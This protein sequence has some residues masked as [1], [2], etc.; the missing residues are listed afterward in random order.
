MADLVD[1]SIIATHVIGDQI[2]GLNGLRLNLEQK[3][4]G[5]VAA[6]NQS[7]CNLPP[8]PDFLNCKD[9]CPTFQISAIA[10]I[11]RNGKVF[12][13]ISLYRKRSEKFDEESFR[14]LEIIASQTGI[15]LSK[16]ASDGDAPLTDSVTALPNGFQLYLM[17]DQIAM[18]AHR[19]E[20]PLAVFSIHL[21]DLTTIRNKWG[22]ITRDECLRAV[23]K[24]LSEGLRD[25]DLLVRYG[26]DDFVT[27]NPRMDREQAEALKSRLQNELD[28][29]RFAV[30]ADEHFALPA[31]IG[32]ASFPE[33]GLDIES[34]L[35]IA[36]WRVRE[37]KE[38]RTAVKS[39]VKRIVSSSRSGSNGNNVHG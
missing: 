25:T 36:E 6:N 12:G 29:F 26:H 35:S 14:R 30:R 8:F 20:Y 4:S 19:Y 27:L 13:A 2:E 21:D 24:H 10:P 39:N 34:L 31:S 22:H 3:L 16:E 15:A 5:W 9:P 7:L 17:F 33:D 38:L 28:H 11:N 18:D 32:I 37:D 23:A 1:Q